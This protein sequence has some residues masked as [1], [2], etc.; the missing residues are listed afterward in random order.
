MSLFMNK[1]QRALVKTK[2][3]ENIIITNRPE[4]V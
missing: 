2:R 4:L 1:L 3:H